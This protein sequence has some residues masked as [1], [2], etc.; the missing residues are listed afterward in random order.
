LPSACGPAAPFI[1][2]PTTNPA[3]ALTTA[4]APPAIMSLTGS[5]MLAA[6]VDGGLNGGMGEML[7]HG[8]Y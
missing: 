4:I 6:V 2:H 7:H 1:A 8:F 3:A 5:V